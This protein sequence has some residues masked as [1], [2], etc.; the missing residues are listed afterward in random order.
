MTV[1]LIMVSKKKTAV[2]TNQTK[3][4]IMIDQRE[5]RGRVIIYTLKTQD[6]HGSPFTKIIV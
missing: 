2:S 4:D 5:A 3:L 1:T 6:I